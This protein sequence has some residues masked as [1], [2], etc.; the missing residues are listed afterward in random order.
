MRIHP[1][2]RSDRANLLDR[3]LGS[4]VRWVYEE[5]YPTDI[6]ERMVEHESL[7]LAVVPPTPMRPG[8]KGPT[9]FDLI[10]RLII[11]VKA[12]RSYHL[13]GRGFD[14]K[15]SAAGVQRLLEEGLEARWLGTALVRMLLPDQGIGSNRE[16][17]I[18][19]RWG[20]GAKGHQRPLQGRLEMKGHSRLESPR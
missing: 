12:R 8:E 16:E 13:T 11:A 9:D 7:H 5:D 2:S 17:P 3:S 19:V 4:V 10:G 6:A 1:S 15:Q 14:R 20:Q 18:V